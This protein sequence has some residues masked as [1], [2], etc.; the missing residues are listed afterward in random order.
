MCS[1]ADNYIFTI[2]YQIK[3]LL[4]K[5]HQ[6]WEN[7]ATNLPGKTRF[8]FIYIY[9]YIYIYTHTHTTPCKNYGIST[10]TECSLHFFYLA[11]KK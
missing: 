4:L 8:D 3:K 10:F 9:I 11:V 5:V 6:L 1:D 2:G 7:F